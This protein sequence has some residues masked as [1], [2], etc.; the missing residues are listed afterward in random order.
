MPFPATRTPSRPRT[1]WPTTSR[2]TSTRMGLPVRTGVRV[3][4][5]VAGG[6]RPRV[7][8]RRRRRGTIEA[9]AGRG[10]DRRL[11]PTRGSRTSPATSIRRS[12]SSTR[13]SSGA[14]RSCARG[15]PRRR[16]Q[17]LGRGDRPDGG[18]RASH[19]ALR[20]A[21]SGKMP[22]RPEDRLARVFDTVLL[23]LRQPHRHPGHPDRP[24]GAAGHPRSRA[25][26]RPRSALGPRRSGR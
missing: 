1:R 15:G 21:T 5:R 6:G 16:R 19:R 22:F 11:R 2:P 24:Q 12:R 3:D 14:S 8:R 18:A 20:V 7:P 13:A 17:Q 10:R 23:V 26:A 25:S 4:R 9:R